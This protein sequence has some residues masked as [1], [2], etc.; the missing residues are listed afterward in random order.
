M[1]SPSKIAKNIPLQ[2]QIE[3]PDSKTYLKRDDEDKHLDILKK[4]KRQKNLPPINIQH[5]IDPEFSINSLFNSSKKG[6]QSQ[7]SEKVVSDK[8]KR[9][10]YQFQKSEREEEKISQ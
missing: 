9:S 2:V 7:I 8:M 3:K 1:I 4:I 5:T 6:D 10:G